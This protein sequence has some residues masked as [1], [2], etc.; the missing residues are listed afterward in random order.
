MNTPFYS[1]SIFWRKFPDPLARAARPLFFALAFMPCVMHLAFSNLPVENPAFGLGPVA[2]GF[3]LAGYFR[4]VRMNFALLGSLLA[5]F[6]WLTN[7]MM[8]AGQACCSPT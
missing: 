7:W 3:W 4:E 5:V 6:L 8:L 1:G 2:A